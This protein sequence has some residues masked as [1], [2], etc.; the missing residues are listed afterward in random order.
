MRINSKA[1]YIA[2]VFLTSCFRSTLYD[3]V[4]SSPLGTYKVRLYEVNEST[5]NEDPWPYK[6]FLDVTKL[7]EKVV[8]GELV[9]VS[10]GWGG[11]F[12]GA[13]PTYSWVSENVLRLGG[14]DAIPESLCDT[15]DIHNSTLRTITYIMVSGRKRRP[16]EKF[17]VLNLMPNSTV[18]LKAQPQTDQG[19]D[20][21]WIAGQVKF[22]DGK[23]IPTTGANFEVSGLYK[24]PSRYCLVIKD[25]EVVIR[26]ID[27]E[28]IKFQ[29]GSRVSTPKVADCSIP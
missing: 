13:Y 11:R 22:A 14:T 27:F 20:M 23:S 12:K 15:V 2:I 29:A 4:T 17:L 1:V 24:G 25:S 28:G 21:S 10:E 9:S 19:A 8:S 5:G 7:T 6:V 3:V 26:S 18:S 16:G